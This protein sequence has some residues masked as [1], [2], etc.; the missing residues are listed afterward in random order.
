MQCWIVELLPWPTL[1]TTST[2]LDITS[3]V[4]KALGEAEVFI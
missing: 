3:V 2:T 1:M 4:P